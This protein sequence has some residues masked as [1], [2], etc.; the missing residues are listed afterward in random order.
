MNE[1]IHM[2]GILSA[3]REKKSLWLI[4]AALI[5]GV[6]MMIFGGTSRSTGDSAD[7][8]EARLEKLCENVYGASEV[9]VMVRTDSLGEVRGV[10]VVCRG[11]EDAQ[12]RLTLTEMLTALFGIPSSAISVVSGK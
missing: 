8:L 12:V 11:G 5:L 6:C 9:S 7:A 3:L 4:V 2:G 1:A 10:A